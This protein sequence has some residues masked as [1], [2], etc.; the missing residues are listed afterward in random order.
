LA[1]DAHFIQD[2]YSE[3]ELAESG[4]PHVRFAPGSDRMADISGGPI[5]A[6]RRH[7]GSFRADVPKVTVHLIGRSGLRLSSGMNATR[8]MSGT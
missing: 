2:A 1:D 4:L 6:N 7:H 3:V 8:I 5:S